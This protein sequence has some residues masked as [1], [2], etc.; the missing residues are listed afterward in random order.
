[1]REFLMKAWKTIFLV[2]FSI[3]SS[4]SLAQSGG[5]LSVAGATITNDLAIMALD[6][7]AN[8]NGGA[9]T[10]DADGIVVC[11]D[12]DG[13]TTPH[14]VDTN[15][16]LSEAQVDSY[17]ANN[18]YS[19][20]SHT[21]D[22][23]TQLSEAQVDSYV[24]NNG[25]STGP[26]TVDTTCSLSECIYPGR[27]TLT[28]DATS[29]TVNCVVPTAPWVAQSATEDNN[30]LSVTYGGGLFVAVASDGTNR[31]M[32]SPDGITW[33]AQGAAEPNPWYSVTYGGGLF[34]A[35]SFNG[36]NQVMTSPDGITWTARSAAEANGW[37]SVTYGGG[38]F[39]AVSL[40]G[41]NR[42]MTSPD[43]IT[44]T[45]RSAAEPNPWF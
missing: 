5:D 30:W 26:H 44:W 11:S 36:T 34:V 22:T 10:T 29:V 40:N 41:T 20:G 12:D 6:C 31:V 15:T 45:A 1:M 35:V 39:V 18:G 21:V 9:L 7:T 23:N 24:A 27:A 38:F 4:L 42:V 2:T 3:C 14:T 17:V 8:T 28:C 16:Q 37:A 33:T 19:I 32:T 13:I 25:Y 43:G